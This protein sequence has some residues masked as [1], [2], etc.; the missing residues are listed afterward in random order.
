MRPLLNKEKRPTSLQETPRKNLAGISANLSTAATPITPYSPE[1]NGE[2]E[3]EKKPI[4][5]MTIVKKKRGTKIMVKKMVNGSSSDGGR[6]GS[7][8]AAKIT[9]KG[10]KGKMRRSRSESSLIRLKVPKVR[11]QKSEEDLA[12]QLDRPTTGMQDE[13]DEETTAEDEGG[14]SLEIETMPGDCS[15]EKASTSTGTK[16]EENGGIIMG[17]LN[18]KSHREKLHEMAI[19]SGKKINNMLMFKKKKMVEGGGGSIN[20]VDSSSKAELAVEANDDVPMEFNG[21]MMDHLKKPNGN[22]KETRKKMNPRKKR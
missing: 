3:E 8:K 18:K 5:M 19:S 2:E 6:G 16:E 17:P 4:K 21:G 9:R 10:R 1:Q 13:E 12:D 7:V 20:L 14:T 22:N 15:S 11:I